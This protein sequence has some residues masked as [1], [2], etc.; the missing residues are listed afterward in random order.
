MHLMIFQLL[1]KKTVHLVMLIALII[2]GF[3]SYTYILGVVD[4][5]THTIILDSM[6]LFDLVQM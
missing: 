1:I 6:E 4:A 2:N 3:I 5:I